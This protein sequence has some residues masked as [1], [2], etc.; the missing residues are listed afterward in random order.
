MGSGLS[1]ATRMRFEKKRAQ[2]AER[3]SAEQH[4]NYSVTSERNYS[5]TSEDIH[6]SP[7]TNGTCWAFI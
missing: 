7:R 3:Q 6:S 4:R 5:V 1:A 2:Y